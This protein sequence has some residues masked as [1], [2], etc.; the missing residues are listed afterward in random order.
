MEAVAAVGE[1]PDGGG[2]NTG[3]DVLAGEVVFFP[4][5]LAFQD[6][7]DRTFVSFDELVDFPFG[8]VAGEHLGALGRLGG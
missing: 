4:A 8:V 2:A 1:H 6:G 3:L 7:F 5:E